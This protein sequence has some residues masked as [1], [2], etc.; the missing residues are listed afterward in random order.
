MRAMA[1]YAAAALDD[2]VRPEPNRPGLLQKTLLVTVTGNTDFPRP[3][4]PELLPIPVAV[5]IMADRTVAGAGRPVHMRQLA[6][7][8]GIH[9]TPKAVLGRLAVGNG[10]KPVLVRIL[11]T[12]ITEQVG[13]RGMLPLAAAD[14]LFMAGIT[15]GRKRKGSVQ[16]FLLLRINAAFGGKLIGMTLFALGRNRLFTMETVN[17]WRFEIDID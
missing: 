4:G 13:R 7:V 14:L 6:P 17:R 9:M 1:G 8:T 2:P 5:R 12:R 16:Q 10:D 11:V 3:V 15:L